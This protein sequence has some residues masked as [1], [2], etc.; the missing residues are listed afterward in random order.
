MAVV[1][2]IIAALF[3]ILGIVFFCG[4]GAWLIAGYNTMSPSKKAQYD[5]KALCKFMGR[6]M[7]L[8]ADCLLIIA[9]SAVFESS[10]LCWIGIGLVIIITVI[11]IV[12]AKTGNRFKL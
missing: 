9:V 7:F 4:K 10:L 11:G 12:Y 1:Y 5:K 6:L 2:L 8:F 3:L